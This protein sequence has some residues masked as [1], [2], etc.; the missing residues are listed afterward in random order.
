MKRL[1]RSEAAVVPAAFP[2]ITRDWQTASL[3]RDVWIALLPVVTGA[4]WKH[5]GQAARLLALSVLT[6][7]AA[8]FLYQLATRRPQTIGDGSAVV[9]GLVMALTLPASTPPLAVIGGAAAAIGLVKLLSGGLGKNLLNPALAG[10]MLIMLIWGAAQRVITPAAPGSWVDLLLRGGADPAAPIGA[11]SALLVLAGAVY[12]YVRRVIT[13]SASLA[14][15]W[16]ATAVYWMFGASP[17]WTAGAIRFAAGDLVMLAGFFIVTDP[18]TSPATRGGRVLAGALAG[19]LG[20]TLQLWGGRPDGLLGAILVV[21]V[22]APLIER[23]TW[24]RPSGIGGIRHAKQ[25]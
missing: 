20:V 7:V 18:V 24:P 6:C 2:H 8:E 1:T 10:H 17:L 15:I 21:N 14:F 16:T 5:G 19:A 12:L 22:L 4:I 9:T 11:V 3:M 23:C 13:W 25:G